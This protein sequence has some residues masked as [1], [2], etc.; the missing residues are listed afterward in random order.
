[1]RG[2]PVKSIIRQNILEILFHLKKGYGYQIAKIY[3]EVF[4]QVTQRSIYYH[5]RKG[6]LTKEIEIHKIEQETGDFSWG[7][8][9]EKKY[10]SLGSLAQA[11]GEPRVEEFL[12]KMG[13]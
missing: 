3:N 12:K 7:Q 9:V 5:L 11:K 1:M 10:Y 2:R 4:P 6:I 13:Q 8:M